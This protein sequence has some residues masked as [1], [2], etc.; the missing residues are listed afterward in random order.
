MESTFGLTGPISYSRGWPRLER[1]ANPAAGAN[2]V[3]LVPGDRIQRLLVARATLT[4][5]EAA[6]ERKP[7]LKLLDAD[8]VAWAVFG[9][10]GTVVAKGVQETTWA[11]D[12]GYAVTAASGEAQIGIPALLLSPGTRVEIAVA[13]ID[14][15][16]QLS[17]VSLYLEEWPNGPDGYPTGVEPTVLPPWLLG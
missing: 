16:D 5:G 15:G 6:A 9:P 3:H 17:A 11:A 14:A 1:L 2:A 7:A 13:A 8:G 4:A 12:L 10:S